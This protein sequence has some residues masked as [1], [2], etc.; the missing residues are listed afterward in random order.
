MGIE[1][2]PEY[3]LHMKTLSMRDDL[4]NKLFAGVKIERYEHDDDF[5]LDLKF[6][7]DVKLTMQNGSILLGQEKVLSPHFASF[8]TFTM[9]FYQNRWTKEHGEFFEIASQYYLHGYASYDFSYMVK[10]VFI[11][12]LR[13]VHWLR[14]KP[15]E[16]LEM[17]TRPAGGSR[18]SFYYI[19]YK[20]I[21]SEFVLYSCNI[22]Q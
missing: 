15:I 12:M 4:Y 20:D 22:D 19:D 8:N 7:I 14:D 13:F 3:Q 9:E 2:T 11:D 6:H 5:I 16:E 17:Q 1:S 18:A 10:Y 21:P